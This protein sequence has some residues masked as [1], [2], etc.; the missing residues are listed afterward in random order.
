MDPSAVSPVAIGESGA[1][2]DPL[3]VFSGIGVSPDATRI[4]E[5][6]VLDELVG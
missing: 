2:G 4:S 3:I 5:N 6:A 1:D